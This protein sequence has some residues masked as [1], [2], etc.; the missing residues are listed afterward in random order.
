LRHVDAFELDEGR[1]EA[2]QPAEPLTLMIR[3]EE[4]LMSRTARFFSTALIAFA[5]SALPA[6]AWKDIDVKLDLSGL[7]DPGKPEGYGVDLL[8]KGSKCVHEEDTDQRMYKDGEKFHVSFVETGDGCDTTGSMY[9]DLQLTLQ[10]EFDGVPAC[11]LKVTYDKKSDQHA[12]QGTASRAYTCESTT[13]NG[14]TT[15]RISFDN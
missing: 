10:P 6:H 4:S 12:L 5:L 3:K 13:V 15:L 9:L 2:R 11:N 14:V 8:R 7:N 1:N